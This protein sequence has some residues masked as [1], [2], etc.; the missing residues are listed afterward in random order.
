MGLQSAPD[1]G[2]PCGKEGVPLL[3]DKKNTVLFLGVTQKAAKLQVRW[4]MMRACDV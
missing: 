3:F 2:I 1:G 4:W